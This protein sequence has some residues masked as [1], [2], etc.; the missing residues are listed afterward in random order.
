MYGSDQQ[1]N[2]HVSVPDYA[3]DKVIVSTKNDPLTASTNP[4]NPLV[5]IENWMSKW[6]FKLTKANKFTF[7]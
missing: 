4:Q 5:H 2:L 1:T 6:R 3:D 7:K